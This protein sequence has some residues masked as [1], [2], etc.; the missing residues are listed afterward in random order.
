VH[1]F[2]AVHVLLFRPKRAPDP[3]IGIRPIVK[4][5]GLGFVRV[6]LPKGPSAPFTLRNLD[7]SSKIIQ[8]IFHTKVIAWG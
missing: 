6:P 5:S 3:T 4:W 2:A 7:R 8:G 1:C